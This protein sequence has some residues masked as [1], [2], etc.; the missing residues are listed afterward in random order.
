[1]PTINHILISGFRQKSEEI[2]GVTLLKQKLVDNCHYCNGHSRVDLYPWNVGWRHVAESL[3]DLARMKGGDLTI[4]VSAF[5]WGAGWGAMQLARELDRLGLRIRVMILSDPVYRHPSIFM[6]WLTLAK[7]GGFRFI[8]YLDVFG[9]LPPGMVIRVP[10][11]VDEVHTLYQTINWPQGSILAYEGDDTIPHPP[12][13]LRVPHE[14]MDDAPEFHDLVL[15]IA[16]RV[17][18]DA[19]LGVCPGILN[20]PRRRC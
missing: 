5:S 10:P 1:M 3:L 4:C 13:R 14:R 2:N 18:E 12:I 6:R 9:V 17:R 11:N 19:G 15:S 20:S 7:R 16:E 8:K